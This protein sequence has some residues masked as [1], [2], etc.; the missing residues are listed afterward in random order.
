MFHGELR[1]GTV[2][3]IPLG[4]GIHLPVLY[5]YNKHILHTNTGL[6]AEDFRIVVLD[7]GTDRPGLEK[8]TYAIRSR[9][10]KQ[11]TKRRK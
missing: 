4:G 9:E 11:F 7:T 6:S 1:G 5:L 10:C 2:T 3:Y 8:S